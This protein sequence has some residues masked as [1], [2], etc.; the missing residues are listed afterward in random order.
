MAL[1]FVEVVEFD[2]PGGCLE[3][4]LDLVD[5]GSEVELVG[6][7][8]IEAVSRS[9]KIL[10]TENGLTVLKDYRGRRIGTSL[11]I[12]AEEFIKSKFGTVGGPTKIC[13][14]T[15]CDNQKSSDLFQKL[16]YTL[17]TKD[18]ASVQDFDFN[19]D[20]GDSDDELSESL[21]KETT[22]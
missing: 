4:S 11:V 12:K 15:H 21:L 22:A 13:F 14:L 19:F 18:S 16:G 7:Y 6:K 8:D 1:E 20:P 5:F 10:V 2:R 9:D 17:V 3:G